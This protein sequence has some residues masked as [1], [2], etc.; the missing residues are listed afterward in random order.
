[1]KLSEAK[2]FLEKSGYLVENTR[3]PIEYNLMDVNW[4]PIHK[5]IKQSDILYQFTYFGQTHGTDANYYEISLPIKNEYGLTYKNTTE[6]M[7][8]IWIDLI[9]RFAGSDYE[10]ME[11]F[12]DISSAGYMD[13]MKDG[14]DKSYKNA[15]HKKTVPLAYD[16]LNEEIQNVDEIVAALEEIVIDIKNDLKKMAVVKESVSSFRIPPYYIELARKILEEEEHWTQATDDEVREWLDDE[17][18]NGHKGR[19]FWRAYCDASKT[20]E[21]DYKC[22]RKALDAV[23]DDEENQLMSAEIGML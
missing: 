13:V 19:V 9:M 8:I 18:D 6:K 14:Y 1:M 10:N 2:V 3:R 20:E 12:G 7:P 11:I 15:V 22:V 16:E 17:Y 5:V 21:N 23:F 4:L